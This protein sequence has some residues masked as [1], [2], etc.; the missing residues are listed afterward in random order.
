LIVVLKRALV[1]EKQ[2]APFSFLGLAIQA[3]RG[4]AAYVA[5]AFFQFEFL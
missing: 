4:A 2:P 5:P 1:V 3:L